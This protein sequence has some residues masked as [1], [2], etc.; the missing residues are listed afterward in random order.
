M[1][2]IFKIEIL[3]NILKKLYLYILLG[4]S[5]HEKNLIKTTSK[6]TLDQ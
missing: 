4:I 2:K 6:Y 5:V 3:K 1:T